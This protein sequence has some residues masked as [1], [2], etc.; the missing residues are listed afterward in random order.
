MSEFLPFFG[1]A[2]FTILAFVIALSIIVAIHEYGHYIV[3]RWC[4]IGAEVFSLG[5]GPVLISRTDKRGTRWQIAAIPLGGYVKFLGDANAASVGGTAGGRNTM[6]GAPVWARAATVAAGPFFNF[7]LTLVIFTGLGLWA[8]KATDPLTLRSVPDLPPSYVQELEVGDQ[9]IAV[10][11]IDARSVAQFAAALDQLPI[12]QSLTYT[13]VRADVQMQVQ[14]PYPNTTAVLSVTHDSAADKAGVQEGDV[15]TA[16]NGQNV[17]AFPQM[18]DIVSASNGDTLALDIW[19]NGEIVQLEVTPRRTD[20]PTADGG[21]ETRWLIG[22]SGGI[23]FDP[24]TVTPSI[25]EAISD[26]FAQLWYVLE[27]SVSAIYH[28]IAGQI[29]T[30][31]LSSPV[32]IAQASGAMAAAGLTDFISF[33]GFL[34]AAVGLLNLFPI[35]V[36]DGGHLVFHAYEAITGRK[37]SDGAMRILIA[38]G[39]SLILTMT[40]FGLMND[41]FLC[42]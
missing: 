19:R 42:P 31:N 32:G 34:S 3:G 36:L 26:A 10:E 35:P 20:L 13:V 9:I 17:Y 39:L 28:M 30:C 7:I 2:G 41:L 6:L 37:P 12:Q 29:S 11:D 4:G 33:I 21:F 23:F 25:F 16:I 8:G 5:F 14:G 24:E 1:S 27:T 38:I 22:V 18:V 40:L 15:I